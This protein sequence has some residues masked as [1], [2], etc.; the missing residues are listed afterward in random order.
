MDDIEAALSC[1]RALLGVVARSMAGALE[2]V[3]LPQ[4]RV[5][6]VLSRSGPLRSG[7]LAKHVGV[8]QST[9]TRT[10][11]RLVAGGWV[12]RQ[13]SPENRREVIIAL[14]PSGQELVQDVMRRRRREFRR[15]LRNVSE[16]ER[17]RI[18]VGL[19]AFA[20][21]AGES[22]PGDLLTLGL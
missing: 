7:A 9:F 11:D 14:T 2:Q 13:A 12:T 17:H 18:A 21:A 5:L 4:F 3:T 1:S 15:I 6:V 19:S 10:A 8:H 20:G 16:E 22:Q